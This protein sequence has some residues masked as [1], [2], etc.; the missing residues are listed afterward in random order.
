MLKKKFIS[1]NL[2]FENNLYLSNTII[3]LTEKHKKL[4]TLVF[5]K[6]NA[7]FFNLKSTLC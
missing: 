7:Y 5:L 3:S 4:M 2:G 1:K 6:S